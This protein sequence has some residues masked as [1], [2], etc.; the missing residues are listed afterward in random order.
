MS[1]V[2]AV[3]PHGFRR[4]LYRN[5]ALPLIVGVISVL[6]FVALIAYLLSTMNQVER[7]DRIIAETYAAAKLAVDQE[8]G[9]R[10]F[11]LSGNESFLEP[12]RIGKPRM[13]AQLDAL[14]QLV[15]EDGQQ[16]QRVRLIKSLH[17]QW[18]VFVE[19]VLAQRRAN[20]DWLGMVMSGRGKQEFDQL[21]REFDGFLKI[22]E[23]RRQARGEDA[24]RG[25]V[26]TVSVFVVVS[27]LVAGGRARVGRRGRLRLSES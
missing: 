20:G 17:D 13:Q 24:R 16:V 18:T 19:D 9:M 7:S 11:L 2:P 12:Y 8:T 25:T 4:I 14:E 26:R 5:I 1:A 27:L 23:E 21:R 6:G 15:G 10:G 22:E 3:D